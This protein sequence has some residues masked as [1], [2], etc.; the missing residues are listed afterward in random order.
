MLFSYNWLKELSGTRKSPEKLAELIMKHSF[1]VETVEKFQHG[2][3]DIVIGKVLKVDKHLAADRLRVTQ[4]EVKKGDIREIVCGAPN[5]AA[6]QKVAVILPGGKLPNG[7]TI[8]QA[9]LRGVKSDGMICSEKELGLGDAHAGILVLPSDAPVGRSFA[10]YAGLD[11][12]VLDVKI[13]PDRSSDALS[14]RGLAREIAALEG[15]SLPTV[16][17]RHTPRVKASPAVP[18]ITIT[19]DLCGRYMLALFRGVTVAESPLWLKAR[20]LVSGL[21]PIN[22][23]VDITNYLMLETGQ[24]THAFDADAI[25][26]G[27]VVVRTA[28][29]REKLTLLDGRTLALA[30]EDV[31]IADTRK[32][33][34]LAGVMG[35]RHSA[36]SEKTKTIAIEIAHFHGGAVRKTRQRHGLFTDA[37]YR[38]ERGFDLERLGQALVTLLPLMERLGAGRFVGVRDSF[39][40]RVKSRTIT[41][42][43]SR[44][45]AVL[46]VSVPLF[47]AVQYLA[48][49]GLS[50]KKVANK[51]ELSVSIPVERVD[52][53]DEW[54]LI[55]EIGRLRGYQHIPSRPP[56]VPLQ[57]TRS[58]SFNR[59]EREL[60][61]TLAGTGFDE[62][63]HYS[64]YS[65]KT[66]TLFAL[67]HGLHLPVANPMNPDQALMRL[68]L[69][70]NLLM[71]ATKNARV[72]E[73]FHM[74]EIGQV[75]MRGEKHP[76]EEKRLAL[77]SAAPRALD[78]IQAFAQF[79]GQLENLFA[80]FDLPFSLEAPAQGTSIFHPTRQAAILIRDQG[81]GHMGELHPRLARQI[82]LGG[83]IM[84]AELNLNLF[85]D[86]VSTEKA[87]VPPRR[88]PLAF[89]DISLIGP[90]RVTYREI[91]ALLDE[92]GAPLLVSAELF[93]VY[94]EREEKSYAFHLAFGLED[95]TIKSEEMD[96]VFDRI[97]AGAKEKISYRL[98]L[99]EEN[100][101]P[102]S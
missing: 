83:P 37:S 11:D 4:V 33:L 61:R 85:R 53:R 72:F 74:F 79:R 89:R 65:H 96:A 101:T 68:M 20:L 44:V 87:V 70:P 28:K 10:R 30:K 64:F 98:R 58:A 50:V 23:I 16:T 45:E 15:V 90:G 3:D 77:L 46:G 93:D 62:T 69:L 1:E 73:S 35:G 59:F 80:R 26:R 42:P 66:V 21:R 13:L 41:L 43:L 32:P 40:S 102:T 36:I 71:S 97:V 5:V 67:D 48:L 34:A 56:A 75:F 6:G 29:A 9:E 54:D 63:L 7:T 55:E 60:R 86:Q 51:R 31:V 92:I 14:Y 82:G 17:H 12:T 94:Q 18:K 88:F 99:P 47:E 57:P 2:L 81:L 91:K 27:G 49:I 38:F 84:L 24:P 39:R 78:R 25:G 100:S 52:L 76:Q 19:T 8:K 95:R 22:S